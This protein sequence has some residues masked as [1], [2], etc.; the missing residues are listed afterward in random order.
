MARMVATKASLSI[1]VDALTDAD[2]KSEPAAPSIG[3]EN[4]A[5]LESRLR[6]LEHQSEQNGARSF[7]TPAKKQAKYE[8]SG[9]SRTYNS[10]ADAVDLVSTQ[11]SPAEAALEAVLKVK[12]DKKKAKEERRA[13]KKAEKE[14]KTE[15]EGDEVKE[16]DPDAMEV[17]EMEGKQKR[18]VRLFVS[19]IYNLMLIISAEGKQARRRD[20]GGKEST[21][22]GKEGGEKEIEGGSM[23]G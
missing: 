8:P 18:K 10:K 20:G 12:E 5:K 3:V 2:G 16:Q 15:D 21:E 13:K 1:R 11:R 6:A 9:E 19:T 22:E 7:S 4:R 23:I 17:D 14:G